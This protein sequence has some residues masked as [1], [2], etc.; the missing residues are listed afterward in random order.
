MFR[1]T[2]AGLVLLFTSAVSV[3][4]DTTIKVKA[5]FERI[6]VGRDLT[7]FAIRVIV[8]PDGQIKGRAY[9]TPVTGKWRWQDG[10]FC[11]DL[12][13]GKRDLGPNCQE[14]KVHGN[15]VRFTSDR[16]SGQHADL[17]MN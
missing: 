5:D 13:W 3:T 1:Q 17:T 11:R 9:G 10:F 7:L 6:V 8:S 2:V 15:K 16:G 4:A 14:V 12:Y